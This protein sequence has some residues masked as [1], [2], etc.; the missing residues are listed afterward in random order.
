MSRWIIVIGLAISAVSVGGA[1]YGVWTI[2]NQHRVIS[3]ARPAKAKV[4]GHREKDLKAS[5]LVSKVPLVKYEYTVNQRL[6]TSETVTPGE[7]MLPPTWAESVFTRFPIGMQTD[8]RYDPQ[9]PSQAFLIPKYSVQ[10]YLPLLL[11]LVLGAMGLGIACEQLMSRDAPA[12][13]PTSGGIALG[14]KQH[15][16]ARARVLGSVGVVGLICGG[17]AIMHHL[18]VSTAPHERLGFL[19]EG[20][21]AIAVLSVLTQS[22]MGFRRGFGFGAPV[23][24]IDRLPTIGERHQIHISV[25]TRF[26]GTANLFVNVKCEAKDTRIFTF[27]E[28]KPDIVLHQ[29]HFIAAKSKTVHKGGEASGTIEFIIRDHML[30]ST[31]VD[32]RDTTH[33]VWRLILTAEGSGGRKA[34]TEFIL[35][36]RSAPADHPR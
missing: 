24:T 11:S 25:P 32:S 23:V 15:H 27:S 14:A 16:L 28:E 36:V 33:M 34:V 31:P 35:P 12:A 3:S 26:D 5:G 19:L 29:E 13:M 30:P 4:L 6:Y 22:A 9:D 8:A 18:M 17:P 21:Y 7:M 1:G 2:W 10:P 20:A